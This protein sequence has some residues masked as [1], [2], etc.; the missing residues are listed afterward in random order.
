MVASAREHD[1][2]R[3]LYLIEIGGGGW[4]HHGRLCE[5]KKRKKNTIKLFLRGFLTRNSREQVNTG[6]MV[7]S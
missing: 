4:Q 6:V 1:L 5:E 7:G 3:L 2:D